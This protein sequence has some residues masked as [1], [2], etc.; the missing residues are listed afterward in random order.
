MSVAFNGRAPVRREIVIN[1]NFIEYT[2]T[3]SYPDCF[4]S[5]QNKKDFTVKISKIFQIAGIINRI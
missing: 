2:N 4:I 5:Y 1:N 3:F